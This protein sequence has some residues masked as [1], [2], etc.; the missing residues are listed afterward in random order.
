MHN[1]LPFS[2]GVP[3]LVGHCHTLHYTSAMDTYK[4]RHPHHEA[5]YSF[6]RLDFNP[7]TTKILNPSLSV[8]QK[9]NVKLL[10]YHLLMVL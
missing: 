4:L 3:I 10:N 2:T 6:M 8:L 9:F 5:R 7:F 1:F